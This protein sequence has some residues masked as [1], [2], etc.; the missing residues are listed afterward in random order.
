MRS[1]IDSRRFIS[2][3]FRSANIGTRKYKKNGIFPCCIILCTTVEIKAKIE[4]LRK[5]SSGSNNCI[6]RWKKNDSL[7]AT[8]EESDKP[9]LQVIAVQNLKT[10]E[11][12]IP[13]V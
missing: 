12:S 6:F 10:G 13:F 11:A 9:I 2:F 5:P 7:V 4:K 8:F 1:I 3:T